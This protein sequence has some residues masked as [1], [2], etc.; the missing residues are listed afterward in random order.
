MIVSDDWI[1]R[2]I[3]KEEMELEEGLDV[4]YVESPTRSL[5]CST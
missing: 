2:D 4:S 1:G 3:R 5:P